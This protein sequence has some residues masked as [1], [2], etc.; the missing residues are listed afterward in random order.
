M[1]LRQAVHLK[2]KQPG[3]HSRSVWG[4]FY[5]VRD[6]QV[7]RIERCARVFSRVHQLRNQNKFCGFLN[8]LLIPFAMGPVPSQILECSISILILGFVSSSQILGNSDHIS[9]GLA[10]TSGCAHASW[11]KIYWCLELK[12]EEEEIYQFKI[13][14]VIEEYRLVLVF[15]AQR[16]Y[17]I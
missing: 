11:K 17:K 3:I 5:Q 13:K 15:K 6:S 4:L 2:P 1:D 14:T 12:N 10:C 7:D 8:A 16:C 9:E